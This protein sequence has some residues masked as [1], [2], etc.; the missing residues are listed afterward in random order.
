MSG[1]TTTEDGTNR[2]APTADDDGDRTPDDLAVQV[3]LLQEENQRLRAAYTQAKRATYR[4][5]AVGL[6]GVGL[7]AALGG[8]LFPD[9]RTVLFALA[10][11]GVFAGVLTFYLTPER[12]IPASVGERVYA[13]LADTEAGLVSDL[14][15]SETRIY[16]PSTTGVRLFV[17]Q[18]DQY[19]LPDHDTL[20]STLVVTEDDRSRGVALEPTGQGLFEEFDRGRAAG[21]D[22]PAVLVDELSEALVEQ[23]EILEAA[24]PDATPSEGQATVGVEGSSYG[25]VGGVDHPVASFLAVGLANGLDRPVRV[26]TRVSADARVDSWVDLEWSPNA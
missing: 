17:P 6:F 7:L 22:D 4:R 18:H 1:Q 14:G 19:A 12:F 21:S 23:F 24:Q 8:V 3:E 5:T 10:G 16:V 20:A 11:V 25:I 15:L 26:S 13:A 9:A 2:M